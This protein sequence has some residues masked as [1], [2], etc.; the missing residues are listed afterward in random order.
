MVRGYGSVHLPVTHGRNIIYIDMFKPKPSS[1]LNDLL[2]FI[3]GRPPEFLDPKF[4]AKSDGRQGI[5]II[6]RCSILI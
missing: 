4:V 3:A 2:G 1:G 6:S 5:L